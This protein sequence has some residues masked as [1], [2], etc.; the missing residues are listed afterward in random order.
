MRTDWNTP[1]IWLRREFTLPD[2]ELGNLALRIHHDEDVEVYVD[3]MLAASASGYTADY[4]KLPLTAAAKAC[5][6]LANTCSP[7]IAIRPAAA[8]IS[9]RAWWSVIEQQPAAARS[10]QS[11][12]ALQI[13]PDPRG[14]LYL[15]NREPLLPSQLMKLPIGSIVPRGWLRQQL[16]AGSR[17][18]DRSSDGDFEVVP[19]R[20]QCL[21]CHPKARVTAAGRN[22]PYWLKGFGDLGYVLKDERIIKEARQMDR[23]ASSPARSR[24]A[25]SVRASLK[26]SLEGKP[27]L[28][29]H[30]VMLNVLQSFYEVH[31]RS[32]A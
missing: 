14:S 20:R 1:D 19:V 8:S 10:A 26:T 9:M 32:R 29:P 12:A 7:S 17:W 24:T 4:E 15:G 21:G 27:D 22:C 13:T 2:R 5:S 28:W 11:R 30:M 25:G 6:N 18:H 3:G 16:D 23:G 31:G